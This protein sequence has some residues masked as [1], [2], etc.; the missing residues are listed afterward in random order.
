[1][2]KIKNIDNKYYVEDNGELLEITDKG[3]VDKKTGKIWYKL[4]ENSS[5]RKFIREVDLVEGH[6][7]KYRETRILGTRTTTNKS[8]TEYMT[9]DDL[10][11][12]N[13]IIERAEKAREEARQKSQSPEEK[14]RAQIAK[15]QAK[16]DQLKSEE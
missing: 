1:M 5:N 8:L 12:Y 6:E 11:L 7:L 16:L 14:L 2:V 9:E 13:E 15:L 10:R 4:P 3:S